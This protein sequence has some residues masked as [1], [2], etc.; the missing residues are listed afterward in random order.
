[1]EDT[2]WISEVR[3]LVYIHSN[4]IGIG[5]SG[6]NPYPCIHIYIYIIYIYISY[7]NHNDVIR[8]VYVTYLSSI[9]GHN[10]LQ[11]ISEM[12]S[13]ILVDS[14]LK[15]S[16]TQ[17]KPG[18]FKGLAGHVSFTVFLRPKY[19]VLS[20]ILLQHPKQDLSSCLFHLL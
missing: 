18:I 13:D 16:T 14:H 2:Y 4:S 3:R 15:P 9:H 8:Y 6:W 10:H 11:Q 20:M 7:D 19:S 12:V 1:M 17:G 5:S